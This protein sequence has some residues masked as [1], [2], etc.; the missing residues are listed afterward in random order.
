MVSGVLASTK[1]IIVGSNPTYQ[2]HWGA[3]EGRC[4]CKNIME[5]ERE[6]EGDDIVPIPDVILKV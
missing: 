2:L 4:C 6:R 5:G 3:R 1:F